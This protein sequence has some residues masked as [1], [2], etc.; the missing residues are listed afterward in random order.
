MRALSLDEKICIKGKL[1]SKGLPSQILAR[2]DMAAA[3]RCWWWAFGTPVSFHSTQ[4]MWRTRTV[5]AAACK[6]QNTV[7]MLRHYMTT[8]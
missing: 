5:D 7:A 8:H 2:L 3:V 1:A 6:P 4:K